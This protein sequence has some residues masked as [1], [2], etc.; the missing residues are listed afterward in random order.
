MSVI[1]PEPEAVWVFDHTEVCGNKVRMKE[2]DLTDFLNRVRGE[3]PTCG[4]LL[5]SPRRAT[6]E[7]W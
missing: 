5:P 2:S 6:A 3:C 7:D 4:Q 1:V